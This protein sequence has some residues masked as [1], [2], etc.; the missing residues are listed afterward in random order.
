MLGID[1]RWELN[2]LP[3]EVLYS[4]EWGTCRWPVIDNSDDGGDGER[5]V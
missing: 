2:M 3:T 4:V 5:S 1:A